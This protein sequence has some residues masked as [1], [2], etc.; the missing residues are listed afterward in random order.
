MKTTYFDVFGMSCAACS[1]AIKKTIS[2]LEGVRDVNV[3]LLS[4]SMSV[5]HNEQLVSAKQIE[6]AVAKAGYRAV[7]KGAE[8]KEKTIA[9]EESSLLKKRLMFSLIF[10]IPLFYLTMGGMVGLPIPNFFKGDGNALI[11]AFTQFLLAS[12]VA[13]INNSFFKKGFYG[14]VKGHATMDSLIAIGSSSSIIYGIFSIYKMAYL[15]G[16]GM[17]DGKIHHIMMELYFES[18]ATILTLVTLGKYMESLAK[19]KTTKAIASLLHLTP[20]TAIVL[21]DGVECQ[22]QYKEINVGDIICIKAGDRLPVDGILVEGCGLLDEAAI[23]GESMP[24]EKNIGESVVSASINLQGYFRF[25]ATKVGDD[26]MLSKI[27]ALVKEASDSSAPIAHVADKVS[28]I[29]VPSVIVLSL[30]SF[31]VWYLFAGFSSAISASISVLVISCPCALGLATPTAIMVGIGKAA[32]L[33]ILIKSGDALE[34]FQKVKKIAFDKTGTITEGKPNIE[35]IYSF[36]ENFSKEELLQIAYS[37][38][39]KSSHPIAFSIISEA[40]RLNIQKKDVESF[41][42]YIAKGVEGK[43]DGELFVIGNLKMMEEMGIS[44][45]S[46]YASYL[47]EAITPLFI[48]FAQDGRNFSII[49]LI[50]IKDKIKANAQNIIAELEGF[51]VHSIMLTGD[52]EVVAKN[53]ASEAGIKEV[54]F[55][56]MPDEKTAIIKQLKQNGEIVAMVGD[57]INDSPSLATADVGVAIGAGQDIAIESA[58]IILMNSSLF[59]LLNAYRLSQFVMKIIKQNLF[60]ALFYNAL[61]IPVAMGALYPS[62]GIKLFPSLAALAMSFSSVSVV[63]NALRINMFREKKAKLSACKIDMPNVEEMDRVANDGG[64]KVKIVFFVEDISCKHCVARIESALRGDSRLHGAKISVSLEEKLVCVEGSD[65]TPEEI[66]SVIK[67]AGYKPLL[68]NGLF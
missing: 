38:E 16:C 3:S 60:W 31:V 30:L 35:A 24:K 47:N 8:P 9:S 12:I 58:S 56:L 1:G 14:L 11:F 6:E 64:E 49:G 7:Q 32:K 10:T 26:T 57:G 25:R 55:S 48:G 45:D 2:T 68:R 15:Y 51:G 18:S 44:L 29:F 34:A 40:E 46:N 63:L 66:A 23:T 13:L 19:A 62:F 41:K 36:S 28:S 61:C 5:V 50:T 37:I 17:Q 21:R 54:Y 59:T 42:N 20:D 53:I 52:C 33:G 4:N 27:I 65:A 22:V 43:I 39:E 67:E